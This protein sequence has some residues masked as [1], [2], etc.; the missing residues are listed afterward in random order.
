MHNVLK[1]VWVHWMIMFS[2]YISDGLTII[3]FTTT[4]KINGKLAVWKISYLLIFNQRRLCFS[5]LNSNLTI[6]LRTLLNFWFCIA[7]ITDIFVIMNVVKNL[8]IRSYVF[9]YKS[10]TYC[11]CLVLKSKK[12]DIRFRDNLFLLKLFDM[13][14]RQSINCFPNLA[15]P[16]LRWVVPPSFRIN[17]VY[18]TRWTKLC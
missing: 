16:S 1:L 3:Q 8:T 18:N 9:F 15:L 12:T 5:L 4:A 11:K 2:K 7:K 14:R 10:K 13:N 6:S 17:S